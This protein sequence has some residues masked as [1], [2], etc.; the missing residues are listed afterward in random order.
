MEATG[1]SRTSA[2]D[3]LR[4]DIRMFWTLLGSTGRKDV[5]FH[6][7]LTSFE[8]SYITAL[9]AL[10]LSSNFSQNPADQLEST[11]YAS[12]LAFAQ[13]PC[14]P[15]SPS[16]PLVKCESGRQGGSSCRASSCKRAE[17]SHQMC[18]GDEQD[19][20]L[21]F[22]QKEAATVLLLEA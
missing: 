10:K 12:V 9:A 11:I 21:T 20:S 7:H 3:R 22:A 6:E 13:S 18:K 17:K 15:T 5:L 19:A 14:S 16:L 2:S 1:K 4:P 8:Q